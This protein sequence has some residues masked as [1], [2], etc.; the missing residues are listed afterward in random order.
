ARTL[1]LFPVHGLVFDVAESAFF[2]IESTEHAIDVSRLGARDGAGEE[3]R[4]H[5]GSVKH[6]PITRYRHAVAAE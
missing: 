5:S 2:E 6:R 4:N 1:E 3:K